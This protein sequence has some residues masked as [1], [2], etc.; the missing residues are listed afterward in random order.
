MT[1]INEIVDAYVEC[2]NK[3]GFFYAEMLLMKHLPANKPNGKC[4]D[5][6]KRRRAAFLVDLKNAVEQDVQRIGGTVCR[7]CS[8]LE[9]EHTPRMRH[10]FAHPS[11]SP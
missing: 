3:I 11:R 10:K 9:S 5:V 6:P 4:Y 1:T 2:G 7:W 8:K